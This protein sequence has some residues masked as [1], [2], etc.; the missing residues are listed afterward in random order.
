[1]HLQ[2]ELVHV[3]HYKQLPRKEDEWYERKIRAAAAAT[4]PSYKLFWPSA[5]VGCSALSNLSKHFEMK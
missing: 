5:W 3:L 1:M 2:Q 4:Y